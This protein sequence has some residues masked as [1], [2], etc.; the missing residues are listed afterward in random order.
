VGASLPFPERKKAADVLIEWNGLAPMREDYPTLI[1]MSTLIQGITIYP[2]SR[3]EKPYSC[4]ITIRSQI[5]PPVALKMAS[6]LT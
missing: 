4:N 2:L 3:R 5:P 1:L 6:Y